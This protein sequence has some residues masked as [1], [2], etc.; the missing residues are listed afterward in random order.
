VNKKVMVLAL[1]G[2]FGA[3]SVSVSAG[4]QDWLKDA[5][6]VL[7]SATG[8]SATETVGSTVSST[9]S[10]DK[11]A[12]GLKEALDV[13]VK[14][15]IEI[16]GE[17]DGFLKDNAVKI[18]MPEQ[19]NQVEKTLRSFGQDE[20][21][22]AFVTSMNRAAEQAVPHVQDTFMEA[23]SKMTLEDAQQILSGGDTAATDYFKKHTS[24]KLSGLI[25]PEVTK[26]M[27]S[28]Q[29]TQYYKAMLSQI[30]RYDSFGLMNSYLGDAA[31]IDNYV[32]EKTMD[33]LFAKIAEQEK[34]IRQNPTARS[35]DL[36]KEVFG[37]LTK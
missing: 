3:M 21:A 12:A 11:I 9:L 5:D 25:K 35:T 2:I 8:K 37:S 24:D 31:D 26:A 7:K 36:L 30:K 17:N 1:A 29:V 20:M 15:A 33:G 23:I 27:G 18:L 10:N 14:K 16:L 34:L 32:T 28:N 22:D 4:W 6:S 19:L 13:G